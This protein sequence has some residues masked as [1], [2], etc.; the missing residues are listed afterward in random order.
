MD[1]VEQ[2]LEIIEEAS[3]RCAKER[4]LEKRRQK[5]ME[6]QRKQLHSS[7]KQQAVGQ[8]TLGNEIGE[9]E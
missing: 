1:V 2:V 6:E 8:K 9:K 4:F 5:A 3:Q 7:L